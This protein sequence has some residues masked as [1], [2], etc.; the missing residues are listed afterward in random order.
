MDNKFEYLSFE[1]G[2]DKG[3]VYMGAIK[4]IEESVRKRL[5][6]SPSE[7]ITPIFSIEQKPPERIFKGISGA[8]AGAINAFLLCCGMTFN[9]IDF[10][11]G[12]I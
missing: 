9:Y 4:A 10:K 3:I 12:K 11:L 7:P 2:G 6:K 5:K 1:G 8:S